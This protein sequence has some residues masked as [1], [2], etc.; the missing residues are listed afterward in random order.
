MI[1]SDSNEID[2]GWRFYAATIYFKPGHRLV[3]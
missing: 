3:E 2:T 1:T